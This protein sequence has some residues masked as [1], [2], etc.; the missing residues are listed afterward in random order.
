MRYSPV[1]IAAG[2]L[3]LVACQQPEDDK[4][5]G[6]DLPHPD[7]N[8]TQ[9]G[10]EVGSAQTQSNRPPGGEADAKEGVQSAQDEQASLSEDEAATFESEEYGVRITYPKTLEKHAGDGAGNNKEA[11]WNA[12]SEPDADGEQLITLTV[13]GANDNNRAE[14]RMGANRSTKALSHCKDVPAGA[15]QAEGQEN[16]HTISGVPFATFEVDNVTQD[17]YE[18]IRSYRATY[19]EACYAIDLIVSGTG[20]QNAAGEADK[21]QGKDPSGQFEQL[22]TV[23]DG[24]EFTK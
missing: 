2:T 21:G 9:S 18:R 17:R 11:G 4:A 20:N 7:I 12:F 1:L 16:Q 6:E 13:P 19:S 24:V 22:Q 3:A 23:L 15:A 8:T 14:F 5:K 10:G